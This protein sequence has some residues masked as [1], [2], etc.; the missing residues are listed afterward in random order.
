MFAM[1]A[2]SQGTVQEPTDHGKAA[3]HTAKVAAEG[4]EKCRL[5]F[6][7]FLGRLVAALEKPAC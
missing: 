7:V 5:G 1:P 4:G 6:P 3:K 2:F